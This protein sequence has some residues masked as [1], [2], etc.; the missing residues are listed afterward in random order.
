MTSLEDNALSAKQRLEMIKYSENSNHSSR[1]SSWLDG[2]ESE[3]IRLP[4]EDMDKSDSP[5]K[6]INQDSNSSKTCSSKTCSLIVELN[7]YKTL[8]DCIL[9]EQ[10]SSLDDFRSASRGVKRRKLTKNQPRK[11]AG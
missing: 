9:T 1:A 5:D 7:K 10:P 6:R 8:I 4:K 2:I 11:K 3:P